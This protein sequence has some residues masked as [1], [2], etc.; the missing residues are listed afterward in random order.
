MAHFHD[1]I[2]NYKMCLYLTELLTKMPTMVSS[3]K[4]A[5]PSPYK[6]TPKSKLSWGNKHKGLMGINKMIPW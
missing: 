1:E 4:T 2:G 5:E 6:V 3:L